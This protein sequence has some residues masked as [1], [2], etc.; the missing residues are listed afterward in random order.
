MEKRERCTCHVFLIPFRACM[1]LVVVCT[2][3]CTYYCFY[4]RRQRNKDSLFLDPRCVCIN[5]FRR[6]SQKN[7]LNCLLFYPGRGIQGLWTASMVC[8]C[9]GT[10]IEFTGR[11]SLLFCLVYVTVYGLQIHLSYLSTGH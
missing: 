5:I 7:S 6:I 1:R 11:I 10:Y 3:Y 4:A 2:L 9:V 8:V